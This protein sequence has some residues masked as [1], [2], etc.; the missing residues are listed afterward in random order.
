LPLNST[1]KQQL[2]SSK[3]QSARINKSFMTLTQAEFRQVEED[4]VQVEEVAV[5]TTSVG[6]PD[7]RIFKVHGQV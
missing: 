4:D 7:S 2:I 6:S 5:F 3:H 1:D